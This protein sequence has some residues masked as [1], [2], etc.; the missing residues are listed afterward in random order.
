PRLLVQLLE[1]VVRTPVAQFLL[2]N[3]HFHHDVS[4]V[5]AAGRDAGAAEEQMTQAA[6]VVAHFGSKTLVLVEENDDR[7]GHA[8]MPPGKWTFHLLASRFR[9]APTLQRRHRATRWKTCAIVTPYPD[10]RIYSMCRLPASGALVP[11]PI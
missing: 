4:Q 10:Y 3:H 5:G 7:F 1:Q 8:D 11:P 9:T 6:E 2:A